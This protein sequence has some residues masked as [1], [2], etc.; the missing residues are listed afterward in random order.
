MRWV[1]VAL[2]AIAG[3][4]LIA[5]FVR[6]RPREWQPLL[7]LSLVFLSTL[8]VALAI[9]WGRAPWGAGSL[10]PT[11]YAAPAAPTLLCMYFIWEVCGPTLARPFGR[12]AL[13]VLVFAFL[14]VNWMKGKELGGE[15]RGLQDA[16]RAGVRAGKPIPYLISRHAS[17]TY[18]VHEQ[19]EGF[20][21]LLRDS[22]YGDYANLP[23]D[24]SF[25]EVPLTSPPRSVRGTTW[26]G[27]RGRSTSND[28]EIVFELPHPT[29]IAGVRMRFSSENAEGWNPLLEVGWRRHDKEHGR[30]GGDTSVCSC[31]RESRRP[32]RPGSMTRW[33]GSGSA[34]TSAPVTSRSRISSCWCPILR[35]CGRST[36]KPRM[37]SNP[38][39]IP[40]IT[41]PR[42]VPKGI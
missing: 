30:N 12:A 26:D 41:I 3:G 15:H 38:L 2:L 25:R 33:T 9:G 10:E 31:D 20:L 22:G 21:R 39:V 34:R 42:L 16:F 29:R 5:E 40:D 14:V 37:T 36:S 1:I 6:R 35:R 17:A 32:L 19:L 27:Q 18:Y 28:P 24:P 11:R 13:C 7:G 8:V 23:P 4:C